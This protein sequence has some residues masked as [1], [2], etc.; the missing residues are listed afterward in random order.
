MKTREEFWQDVKEMA[1]TTTLNE[2]ERRNMLK[3]L[4]LLYVSGY[5]SDER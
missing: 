1:N 2:T 5:Y 3:A 4:E